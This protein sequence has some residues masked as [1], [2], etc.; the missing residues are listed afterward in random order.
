MAVSR[1]L[2]S[3]YAL[4]IQVEPICFGQPWTKPRI[5]DTSWS[6]GKLMGRGERAGA[7]FQGAWWPQ[8]HG[9]QDRLAGGGR[10]MQAHCQFPCPGRSRF[11]S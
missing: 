6:S 8:H 3:S 2:G 4:V 9:R 7:L 5:S 11:Q 10:V 1:R